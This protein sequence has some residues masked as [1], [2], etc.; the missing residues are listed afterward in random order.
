MQRG[1]RYETPVR[2]LLIIDTEENSNL[3]A[4][5]QETN[6]FLATLT[7]ANGGI[8]TSAVYA[9]KRLKRYLVGLIHAVRR[10]HA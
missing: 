7:T 2:H 6:I 3:W 1:D 4:I 8:D 9:L 10:A 5:T